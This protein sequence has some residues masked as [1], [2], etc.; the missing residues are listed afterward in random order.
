MCWREVNDRDALA[1][2][3][4][5][6]EVKKPLICPIKVISYSSQEYFSLLFLTL[7]QF[8]VSSDPPDI[9]CVALY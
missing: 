3:F 9:L 4:Y 1:S 2:F 6:F 7:R 5:I 8:S